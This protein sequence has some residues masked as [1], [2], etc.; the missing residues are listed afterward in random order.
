MSKICPIYINLVFLLPNLANP[1]FDLQSRKSVQSKRP[2]TL[3]LVQCVGNARSLSLKQDPVISHRA[4]N[5]A[6]DWGEEGNNEII[7]GRREHF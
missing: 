6:E 5:T 2:V 3:S 7:V 1:S 4:N